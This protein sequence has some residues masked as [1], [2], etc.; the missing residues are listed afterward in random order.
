LAAFLSDGARSARIAPRILARMSFH[1]SIFVV[2]L[3]V[4]VAVPHRALGQ[5]ESETAP[6]FNNS[7][8]AWGSVGLGPGN[9]RTYG[10]SLV[11]G[12][13]RAN[14]SVGPWLLTYRNSD[15]GPLMDVGPRIR[16]KALLA[17]VRTGGHRLFAS[18]AIG[19]AR[20]APY[21]LDVLAYDAT[22][23]ANAYVVGLALSLSGG[24]GPSRATYTAVT[25]GVEAGWFG[26]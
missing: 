19:Y 14:L 5:F 2:L 1:L 11:A 15:I 7:V 6:R 26:W 24:I 16:D 25:L 21:D 3:T 23:H 4:V 17:G 22:L 9:T 10:E 12:V 13:L 18:G 8:A 20:A